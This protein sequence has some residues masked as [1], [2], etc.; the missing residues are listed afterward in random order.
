MHADVIHVVRYDPACQSSTHTE[1][2]YLYPLCSMV[3]FL[4]LLLSSSSPLPPP[5]LASWWWWWCWLPL[6]SV[7]SLPLPPPPSALDLPTL[8]QSVSDH[9]FTSIIASS[10]TETSPMVAFLRCTGDRGERF[11]RNELVQLHVWLSCRGCHRLLQHCLARNRCRSGGA[12]TLATT[13]SMLEELCLG[14]RCAAHMEA[15]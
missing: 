6:A 1:N 3:L 9:A 10:L 15:T 7:L 4:F 12:A 8:H 5:L 11:T 14:L 13:C 2:A